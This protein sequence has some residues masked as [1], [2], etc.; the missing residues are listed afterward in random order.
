MGKKSKEIAAGIITKNVM[1]A[2]VGIMHFEMV[3]G[4]VL[5]YVKATYN[6]TF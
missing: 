1:L 4:G 5:C 2:S 6:Y 3:E